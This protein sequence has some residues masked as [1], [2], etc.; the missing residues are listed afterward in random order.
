MITILN[1][2]NLI[3]KT[4]LCHSQGNQFVPVSAFRIR[5]PTHPLISK[6]LLNRNQLQYHLYTPS[7]SVSSPSPHS[8]FLPPSLHKTLTQK[9]EAIHAAPLI[10][11]NLPEEVGGYWGLLPLDKGESSGGVMG[12]RTWCFKAKKRECGKVVVLRRVEGGFSL[13]SLL[14]AFPLYP[15]FLLYGPN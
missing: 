5:L 9:S 11:M 3:N 12:F 2:N 6:F 13:L 1:T 7:P 15:L 4:D 10:D 14:Q 8:F